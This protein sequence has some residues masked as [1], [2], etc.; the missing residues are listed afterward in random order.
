M[1]ITYCNSA[2]SHIL[3]LKNMIGNIWASYEDNTVIDSLTYAEK[4][5]GVM[6][7]EELK[8][9]MR[10]LGQLKKHVDDLYEDCPDIEKKLHITA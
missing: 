2:E 3:H 4:E 5:Y 6:Q 8:E 1:T 10:L 7:R 9:I